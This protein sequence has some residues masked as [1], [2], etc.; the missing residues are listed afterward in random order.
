MESIAICSL[1]DLRISGV[2]VMIK[3]SAVKDPTGKFNLTALTN[4]R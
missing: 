1:W 3:A 4:S 2:P